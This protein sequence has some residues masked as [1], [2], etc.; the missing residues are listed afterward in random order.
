LEADFMDME[1]EF[2]MLK[3]ESEILQKELSVSRTEKESLE[4]KVIE[5]TRSNESVKSVSIFDCLLL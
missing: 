5:L 1:K 4:R 2:E 3:K